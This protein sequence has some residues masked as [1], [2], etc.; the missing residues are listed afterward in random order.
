MRSKLAGMARPP[1]RPYAIGRSLVSHRYRNMMRNLAASSTCLAAQLLI[2]SLGLIAALWVRPA[3]AG[4]DTAPQFVAEFK[5]ICVDN[6]GQLANA[7]TMAT[8][9]AWK[10]LGKN[11]AILPQPK[12]PNALFKAWRK[13]EPDGTYILIGIAEYQQKGKT[14]QVCSIAAID[15]MY[16][17][18][19][20]S[21]LK[22]FKMKE[23][24]DSIIGDDH[25][26]QW[27]M[28]T[29]AGP[30]TIEYVTPQGEARGPAKL[31]VYTDAK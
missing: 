13:N 21:V 20:E 2:A 6:V 18:A 22:T 27:S 24:H 15:L 8:A 19:Q 10:I 28:E 16:D 12:E 11:M 26:H 25:I 29:P 1:W 3:A 4:V 17:R 31:N 5:A 9:Q 23:L 14:S 30:V 7:Q